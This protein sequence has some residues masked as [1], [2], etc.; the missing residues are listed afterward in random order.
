M[1]RILLTGATG[2]VGQAVMRGL[3]AR[4]I[5][6]VCV[7]RPGKQVMGAAKVV[8]VEDIFAQPADWWAGVCTGVDMVLH[9]AWYAEPGKY[10]TSDKNLDCLAGTLALTKGAAEAGVRRFVGV[11]TCFE[12]DLTVGELSTDT[13][14]DPLTPYAAAKAAAFIALDKLAPQVGM[15]FLWARLFYLYGQ[16]EDP[17]RLV[18]YLHQQMQ[19]GERA[20]LTSGTQLRD[21]MDVDAAAALLLDDAF[22]DR[23]GASN[24]ASGQGITVRALAE[25]I[26]DQYGRR[27]LL[28]FGARPDN[29]TDP[30]VVV[31]LRQ[32]KDP[33]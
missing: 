15:E 16:G 23:T 14:L 8:E 19:A 28:N 25:Q 20:D 9:V 4:G 18:P 10:L 3:T 12:Y 17:R 1:S 21:F 32:P 5:A 7:V 29:L 24:I 31:G 27:D 13:K 2:F 30:P 26:A 11:G 6:P 33:A 22:S